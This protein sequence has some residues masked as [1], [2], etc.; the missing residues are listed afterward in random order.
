MIEIN[1]IVGRLSHQCDIL[2]RVID[3]MEINGQN[4]AILYGEDYRLI[5]D[6]P[7]E[8]LVSI[9]EPERFRRSS[10]VR[11]LEEQSFELFRQD[12]DLLRLEQEYKAT[13]GYKKD[14]S[15]F[16]VPGRVLH[17]DGDPSYLKKCLDLY[18]TDG[19]YGIWR[20]L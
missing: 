17:L 3:I 7:T 8:D 9:T 11:S 14:Y 10:E 12:I 6:A 4:I 18:E 13:E 1:M 2:F 19:C 5:A 20:P 15:Y 16:Q